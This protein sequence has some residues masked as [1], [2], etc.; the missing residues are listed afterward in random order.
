MNEVN[1]PQRAGWDGE[2]EFAQANGNA[3]FIEGDLIEG[4]LLRA[5]HPGLRAGAPACA[6]PRRWPERALAALQQQLQ[7]L[8]QQL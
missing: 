1:G 7:M 2:G 5:L 8:Q 4:R 6:P 3:E